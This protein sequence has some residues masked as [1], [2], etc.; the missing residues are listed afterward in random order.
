MSKKTLKLF[1]LLC[2][3]DAL[4]S[5]IKELTKSGYHDV[6]ETLPD[7]PEK[8]LDFIA[9]SLLDP[10]KESALRRLVKRLAY[11]DY[12]CEDKG[13]S[14]E[15]FRDDVNEWMRDSS[16]LSTK[17][18]KGMKKVSSYHWH[19]LVDVLPRA[20]LYYLLSLEVETT[21][22]ELGYHPQI[23]H[24]FLRTKR[25]EMFLEALIDPNEYCEPCSY[26]KCPSGF[27]IGFPK[28][29]CLIMEGAEY[30]MY[31]LI[32]P[33]TKDGDKPSEELNSLFKIATGK[34]LDTYRADVASMA[35]KYGNLQK[36]HDLAIKEL[37]K[38]KSDNHRLT[39]LVRDSQRAEPVNVTLDLP[40]PNASIPN[41]EFT[42]K[43]A[44]ELFL[45]DDEVEAKRADPDKVLLGDGMMEL[46][47]PY[48]EWEFP[49]PDVPKVDQSYVF[50]PDTLP[51]VLYALAHNKNA[52]LT[53]HTGTGKSMLANQLSARTNLP[54]FRVNMDSEITRQDFVGRDVLK[55]SNGTTVSEFIDGILPQALSQPC[56]LQCDEVDF[57]RPDILYALQ[58]ALEDNGALRITEDGGRIVQRHK[59]C[60]IFATA[61]TRGQGDEHG[62]YQGARVQSQAFLDRFPVWVE[63]DY[64][65]PEDEI[66]YLL[67]ACLVLQEETAQR[68]VTVANNIREAFSEGRILSTISPRGLLTTAHMVSMM[69]TFG[70]QLRFNSSVDTS[71]KVKTALNYTVLNKVSNVDATQISEFI[72]SQFV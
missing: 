62:M 17:I 37:G 28:G 30:Q 45:P 43:K 56:I 32:H 5:N 71:R 16:I 44:W 36:E 59:W 20:T 27:Y 34:D 48:C 65:N 13:S 49:H 10:T 67:D 9:P 70:D 14:G 7:T 25:Y 1:D 41:G 24:D 39:D 53:G 47:I 55:Q 31:S 22:Y 12:W 11:E 69:D 63:M 8:Y 51:P 33:D 19:S 54:N 61:N 29:E 42:Y 66:K 23:T 64:M 38:V 4:N 18:T 57:A 52:M 40:S 35:K 58:S 21:P 15:K 68:L 2:N 72:D 50:Y 26:E 3:N 6:S 60:H 46:N